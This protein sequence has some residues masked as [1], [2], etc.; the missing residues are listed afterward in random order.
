MNTLYYGDNLPILR[1]FLA[2]KPIG[3]TVVLEL[4]RAS[5]RRCSSPAGFVITMIK[6]AF[7]RLP[8]KRLLP[9]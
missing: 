3:F 8:S 5:A 1:E 7:A 4:R 6:L 9:R 2:E